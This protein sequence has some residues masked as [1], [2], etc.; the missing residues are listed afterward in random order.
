[1]VEDSAVALFPDGPSHQG[2]NCVEALAKLFTDSFPAVAP[3][4]DK[5]V[6]RCWK[7]FSSPDGIEN[8]PPEWRDSG[9]DTRM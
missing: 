2:D 7:N 5:G 9:Q 1:M 3:P 8:Y 6:L 4:A